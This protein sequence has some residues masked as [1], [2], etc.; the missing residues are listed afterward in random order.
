MIVDDDDPVRI[1]GAR[2]PDFIDGRA[3]IRIH[4]VEHQA[5]DLAGDDLARANYVPAGFHRENLLRNRHA[6]D[7]ALE[8]NG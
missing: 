2:D 3:E 6:H 5:I 4:A 7:C 8:V 1:P